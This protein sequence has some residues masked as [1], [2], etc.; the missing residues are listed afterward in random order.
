MLVLYVLW[1]VGL[2][3]ILFGFIAIFAGPRGRGVPY[4]PTS[5]RRIETM[6]R[7]AGDVRGKRVLDL[8]SGDGRLV[9]T[10]ASA[11]AVAHGYE[12]NP[13]LVWWAR[14]RV[15]LRGLRGRAHI[16][17]GNYWNVNTSRFDIIT[18]FGLRPMMGD[19]EKKLK[20]ETHEGTRILSNTF[21]FPNWKS[22]ADEN[23][24]HVYVQ[25]SQKQ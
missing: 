1:A 24:I 4:V 9:I 14:T 11:G 22:V 20:R 13:V 18:V 7:L 25:G 15:L 12:L 5:R 2:L 21:E 8:G 17:W 19:L 6:L 10:F 3:F 16:H 23:D